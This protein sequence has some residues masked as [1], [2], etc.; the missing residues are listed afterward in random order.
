M[1]LDFYRQSRKMMTYLAFRNEVPTGDLVRVAME[2]GKRVMV[3]VVNPVAKSM[4]PS[5][6]I[7]P[8]TDLAVGQYGILEPRPE[9]FRPVD[10][11]E[12]DLVIIPGVAFDQRGNRV[13]YGGGYYD[14]F[15]PLLREEAVTVA[16]AYELQ[17]WP[18]TGPV[19]GPYDQPVHFIITE[20]R[21]IT[22][23]SKN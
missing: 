20:T 14:R 17:I 1:G 12:L 3:P 2:E 8:A 21:V 6:L 7:N 22:C 19:T 9:V 5:R 23:F 15:I 10:P 18:D 16:L 11:A 4:T 13:G